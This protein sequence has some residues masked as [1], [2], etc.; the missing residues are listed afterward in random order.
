VAEA[1]GVRDADD[2]DGEALADELIE[3]AT[4]DD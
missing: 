1:D 3:D 2:A 4:P